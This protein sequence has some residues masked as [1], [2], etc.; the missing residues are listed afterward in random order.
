[1]LSVAPAALDATWVFSTPPAVP[2]GITV[3]SGQ[4]THSPS[5]LFLGC[6]SDSGY[7]HQVG[8]RKVVSHWRA[9][10]DR[11]LFFPLCQAR[12]FYAQMI[13]G[14]SFENLASPNEPAGVPQPWN[15]YSDPTVTATFATDSVTTFH[16][17]A[18][19]RVTF[20]SGSGAAGVVN[21]GIGALCGWSVFPL[22]HTTVC[23][24]RERGAVV[25][26]RQGLRR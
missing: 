4:V 20:V 5:R 13:F 11:C 8:G 1:V 21:R 26:R 25:Q 15:N 16:G 12:G 18:S 14:E 17:N 6:H 3:V 24:D 22:S 7:T 19:Q 23:V 2:I 10:A 9:S